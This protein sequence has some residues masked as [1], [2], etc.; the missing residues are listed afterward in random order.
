MKMSAFVRA[1]LGT[2]ALGAGAAFAAPISITQLNT[3]IDQ[4]FDT[5]AISGT[6]NPVS[7]LPNGW[8]FVETGG[9]TN[10]AA[11]NGT[12]N[13]GNTYSYGATGSSERAL[14]S[15]AS[16]AVQSQFGAAFVNNTGATITSLTI[17]YTGEQWRFGGRTG[18][19]V[20]ADEIDFAYSSDAS[21]LTTGT[22]T[23][24]P[25]L[26]FPS[27][28]LAGTAGA[29][30]GNDPSNRTAIATTVNGLNIPN[31]QTFWIRWSD[32]NITGSDDA[33]AVDDFSITAAGN[34]GL[35][36]LTINDVSQTEGD[37]GIKTFTFT[38]SLSAAAMSDITFDIATHDATAT[39]ADNDYSAKSLAAQTITA[40][41]TNYTFDVSVNGDV[42]GETDETFTVDLTGVVGASLGDAQGIGT[43]QNDDALTIG[44]IQG[45]GI[46]SSYAPAAGNGNGQI[47]I[48]RD[49]VVTAVGP[50]GFFI[51]SPDMPSINNDNDP[52]TSDGLYVFTSATPTVNIGDMVD[53]TAPVAEY[54]DFTQLVASNPNTSTITVTGNTNL[55]LAIELSAA[56]PSPDP[57]NLSCGDTNWECI[58]GMRVHVANGTVTKANLRR[59]SDN[60][61]EVFVTASNERGFREPHY[62]YGNVQPAPGASEWDGNP[63]IFEMDTDTLVPT[64]G[65]NPADNAMTGGTTFEATGV[66]GYDFGDYEL[67]PTNVTILQANPMPRP[68]PAPVSAAE[69]RLGDFNAERFCDENPKG[70]LLYECV[71]ADPTQNGDQ[72]PTTAQVEAKIARTA[73]YIVA[74][75]DLPDVVAMQEIETK[76]MLDRLSAKIAQ[77]QPGV[78]Y[79][80]Y[81]VDGN[82]PSGIDVGYLV[83]T[84]R[85]SNVSVMVYDGNLD[86]TFNGQ[87][88]R[89]FDHPP[90]LLRG[91]FTGAGQNFPFAL[92]NN[93]LKAR[94]KVDN[95]AD[96]GA[97]RDRAKR[98][99]QAKALA[100]RVQA[101]QSDPANAGVSL[102]VM[103]DLNAFEFGDGYAD[104]LGVI[105]GDYDDNVNQLKLNGQNI[106][107]PKLLKTA[108]RIPE[109]DRYSYIFTDRLGAIMGYEVAGSDTGRDVPSLQ[110]I[111]HVLLNRTAQ[112]YFL[113]IREGR[114]GVDLPDQ[115]KYA[116]DQVIA[117][118]DPSC[119][120]PAIGSSDHEGSVSVFA[121]DRIFADDFEAAP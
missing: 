72:V 27:P 102:V 33:L 4:N 120:D 11:D 79:A 32:P 42:K 15:L 114:A 2:A 71:D 92:L 30:D 8:T 68:V 74:I 98:F 113:S 40:G 43:I 94:S 45:N 12:L 44:Q 118:P 78:T 121:A 90:F 109:D 117:F 7:S 16:N 82:D 116:C 50:A 23:N 24:V 93:H 85:V 107:S 53:I 25:A 86:W 73:D 48:T 51:Q 47:V 58:E 106:V 119:P 108:S 69:F 105:A 56:R 87:T 103:G 112:K 101:F 46:R 34:A 61:A 59:A 83:R 35:P 31:G 95:D 88:E 52:A 13:S 57:N 67:W 115:L 38:V 5:L 91:T 39:A 84:D 66:I 29:R 63:Q 55:P 22:W 99:E 20:P 26:N 76:A 41:N 65:P 1:M 28:N 18:N 21:D 14:G 3:A 62:R 80:T 104:L 97:P 75:L 6:S 111:D 9:D 77:L 54:F 60:Y 70:S 49:N 110:T 10:Y 96:S 64:L 17:A 100:L 89:L 81:L 36:V 37:A 19:P